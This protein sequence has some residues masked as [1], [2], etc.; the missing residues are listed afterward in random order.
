M[1][2]IIG[3]GFDAIGFQLPNTPVSV[4]DNAQIEFVPLQSP[5]ALDQA[6]GAIIPQGIFETIDYQ[7]SYDGTHTEVR[8][9]KALL[10][11]RQKQVF[12]M[13][14]DRKWVCFLLGSIIR[15]KHGVRGTL[16]PRNTVPNYC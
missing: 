11:E 1:L 6:D 3:Y 10:Q 2:R 8:V 16:Q 5:E 7:R 15:R 13:I 12:N 14:E 4:G 9:R